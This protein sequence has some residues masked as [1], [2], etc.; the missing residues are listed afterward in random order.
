MKISGS[1]QS[2]R[3]SVDVIDIDKKTVLSQGNRAMRAARSCSFRFKVRRQQSL[4][5]SE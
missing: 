2:N 4:Q 5:V 3:T 1:V